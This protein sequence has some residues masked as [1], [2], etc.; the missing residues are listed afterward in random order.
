MLLTSEATD[1][2]LSLN[3]DRKKTFIKNVKTLFGQHKHHL[4]QLMPYNP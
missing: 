4:K 2:Y 1:T 3:M